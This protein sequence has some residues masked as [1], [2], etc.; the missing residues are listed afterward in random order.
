MG[1][2][3]QIVKLREDGRSFSEI[4]NI[5]GISSSRVSDIC[6]QEKYKAAREKR[7]KEKY[8]ELLELSTRAQNAVLRTGAH[9]KSEMK[10]WVKEHQNMGLMGLRNV[11]ANTAAELEKWMEGKKDDQEIL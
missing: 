5:F 9:D 2:N 7:L 11:G 8:P 3:Q 10:A 6:R 1:R 4:A